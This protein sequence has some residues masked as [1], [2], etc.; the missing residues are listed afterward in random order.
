MVKGGFTGDGML[1]NF[2]H[3]AGCNQTPKLQQGNKRGMQLQIIVGASLVLGSAAQAQPVLDRTDP[4]LEEEQQRIERLEEREADRPIPVTTEPAPQSFAPGESYAVGAI[5]I[6]GADTVEQEA[7]LPVIAAY[8]ARTLSADD[9]KKLTSSIADV[10]KSRGLIFAS[11][12]IEPQSLGGGVLRIQLDEGVVDAVRIEGGDDPA[13]R[14]QLAPLLDG[15]P[16]TLARLE[17]QM[18]LADDLSGVGIRRTRF[19]R[20]GEAGI[21]VIDAY[22]SDFSAQVELANDGSQPIG[23]ERA[24]IDVDANGLISPFDEVDLTYSTTPFEPS[25]LQYGRARYG[26]VI[27]SSGTE[28]AAS[29][30]YSATEPGAYLIDK[31]FFGKSWR[32]TVEARHPLL[33]SREASLWL[34]GELEIRDLRQ[35][36]EGKPYRHDRLVVARASLYSIAQLGGGRARA[37]L[38]YSQGLGV[39]DATRLGDPMA[40]RTD[41]SGRF[42]TLSAWA[43]WQRDLFSDFSIALAG[44]GQ[45]ASAPLLITEDLGLG[46]NSFLRGYNFSERSGDEGIMGLGEL[47]YDW[48]DALGV[49]RKLQLYA[50]ADGGV[51]GNLGGGRGG[52]SLA[53]GGGGFRSDITREL[54]FDL[55]V[56]VPLTGPRY[57]TDDMSP[58]VN[59]GIRYSL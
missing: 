52:G 15:R 38:T 49:F 44:R 7:F 28:I 53:S 23:P 11:A 43:D 50:F 20:E 58:R 21:L 31:D 45:L 47:R 13:I 40:S 6:H 37:K 51:V 25:E 57:D 41:A 39:L 46:G 54:D 55:E 22:R 26:V 19:V 32:G 5:V 12:W 30:S 8:S 56:A 59:L 48:T 4:T 17:R 3:K 9:L 29:A 34:S 33:R 1:T 2:P 36:R 35:E 27:G 16:V 18:L 42:A 24:R 10:A 14:A